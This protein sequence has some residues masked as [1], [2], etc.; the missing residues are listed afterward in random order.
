MLKHSEAMAAATCV[1]ILAGI[2]ISP[3]FAE[4]QR[5][6]DF[7]VDREL[8][9]AVS[10]GFSRQ[11]W[12]Y[13]GQVWSETRDTLLMHE[14]ERVRVYITNDMPGVRVISFGDDQPARRVRAGET[15]SADLTM[16]HARGFTI[17]VVG[18]PAFSRPVRVRANYV[19]HANMA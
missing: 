17:A 2:G 4:P 7:E 8:V 12:R 5:H 1:A 3:A 9:L 6:E 15:I 18:Q 14:D 16:D 11:T 19:A 10:D 13:A